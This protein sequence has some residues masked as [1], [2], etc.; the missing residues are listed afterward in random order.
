MFHLF[1]FIFKRFFKGFYLWCHAIHDFPCSKLGLFLLRQ[2]IN[3]RFVIELVLIKITQFTKVDCPAGRISKLRE[4]IRSS[5]QPVRL[6]ILFEG[7]LAYRIMRNCLVCNFFEVVVFVIAVGVRRP[8]TTE[9]GWKF[10][11][12]E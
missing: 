12:E 8:H 4:L 2:E 6:S 1:F 10:Q 5:F 7:C 11:M 3:K 9:H